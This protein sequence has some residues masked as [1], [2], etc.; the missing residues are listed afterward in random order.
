M[1]K[2]GCTW[3]FCLNL[4]F[5]VCSDAGHVRKICTKPNYNVNLFTS[6]CSWPYAVQA[7]SAGLCLWKRLCK[8]GAF[9]FKSTSTTANGASVS[10]QWHMQV[11]RQK[12]LEGLGHIL[13]IDMKYEVS[14]FQWHFSWVCI[15]CL[16]LF[17]VS[18]CQAMGK[19]SLEAPS[20]HRTEDSEAVKRAPKVGWV[21]VVRAGSMRR[22]RLFVMIFQYIPLL[23]DQR[24]F[25]QIS[26]SHA[27]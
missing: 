16:S 5:G 3:V 9:L 18:C 19:Y 26:K 1:Q 21:M 17:V 2:A 10:W 22:S 23:P 6:P 11:Q 14:A 25:N 8:M 27:W 15:I 13:N 12:A 24:I 4:A 7:S 20:H